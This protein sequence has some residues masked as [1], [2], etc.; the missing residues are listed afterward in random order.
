VIYGFLV[1]GKAEFHSEE[2]KC[3]DNRKWLLTVLN[4]VP[5]PCSICAWLTHEGLRAINGTGKVVAIYGNIR[6][7]DVWA[8]LGKLDQNAPSII[9]QLSWQGPQTLPDGMQI[10]LAVEDLHEVA[11]KTATK[12]LDG[13]KE[14]AT[15]HEGRTVIGVIPE[16]AVGPFIGKGG[17]NIKQ[18]EQDAGCRISL[19]SVTRE[20]HTDCIQRARIML[21]AFLLRGG[22][23]GGGFRDRDRDQN[24]GPPRD[25]DFDRREHN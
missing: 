17:N 8:Y 14:F 21:D 19:D 15:S 2:F 4:P 7:H 16:S 12:M 25:R 20:V 9:S 3:E 18:F 1:N 13:A 11:T 6:G 22:K 23:G 5:K 10:G 24:R